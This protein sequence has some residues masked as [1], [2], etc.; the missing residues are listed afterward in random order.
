MF[1]KINLGKT[2]KQHREAVGLTQSQLAESLFVSFQAISAWERGI[3]P[4]DLE[5]VCRL[6]EFFGVSVDSLVGGFEEN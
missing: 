1:D 4:P 6:A 3:T 2:I 5:N